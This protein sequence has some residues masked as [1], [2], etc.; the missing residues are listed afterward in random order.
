M[1]PQGWQEAEEWT[2]EEPLKG[3]KP[4]GFQFH[5]HGGEAATSPGVSLCTDQGT[6]SNLV[7]TELSSSGQSQQREKESLSAE[8]Q[9]VVRLKDLLSWLIVRLDVFSDKLRRTL[10]TGRLFPLPTSSRCLSHIFSEE[11]KGL[12]DLLRLVVVSLNSLNGEGVFLDGV[13]PSSFQK[14]VLGELLTDC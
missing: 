8:G 5:Q 7:S 2:L 9:D 6:D 11:P 1:L 3:S 10:P 14:V 4:L 13:T 12:I